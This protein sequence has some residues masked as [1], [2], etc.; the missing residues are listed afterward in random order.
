[1][2]AA[3]PDVIAILR[4]ARELIADPSHWSPDGTELADGRLGEFWMR[5]VTRWKLFDA[6]RRAGYERTGRLDGA[7]V[8]GFATQKALA[9]LGK[10]LGQSD[11]GS[12]HALLKFRVWEIDRTHDEVLDLL[13]RAIRLAEGETQ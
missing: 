7:D 13:D 12:W 6:V 3:D 10:A 8:P 4:R 1:M 2:A 11:A 5:G 9:I